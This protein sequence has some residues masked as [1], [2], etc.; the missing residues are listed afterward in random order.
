[1]QTKYLK[2]VVAGMIGSAVMSGVGLWGAPMMGMQKMNPADLLAMQ[3]GGSAVAGWIAH[4]MIG[5]IL[6]VIYLDIAVSRLPG[7]P[8]IRGALFSIAPWLLAQVVMM[9]IMGM[10]FFSGSFAPAMGSLVGH[11]VYGAVVG[12]IVGEPQAHG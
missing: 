6:A 10:G 5:A 9:P 7:P 2:A 11:L 1:M 4:L 8:A 12:A 3:M